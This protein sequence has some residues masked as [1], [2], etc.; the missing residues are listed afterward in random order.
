[1]QQLNIREMRNILGNLDQLVQKEQEII[2]TRHKK[3]I[4]RIL[5]IQ[6]LKKRPSHA[7]LRQLSQSKI[8]SADLIREDRDER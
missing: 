3:A 7:D 6:P 2:I 4:A 1:M 5:P 8:C